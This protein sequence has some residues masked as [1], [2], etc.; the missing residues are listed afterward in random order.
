MSDKETVLHL[1]NLIIGKLGK[2]YTSSTTYDFALQNPI[3]VR[4]RLSSVFLIARFVLPTR[5]AKQ[6]TQRQQVAQ[7]P[8]KKRRATRTFFYFLVQRGREPNPRASYHSSTNLCCRLTLPDTARRISLRLGLRF[9][10]SLVASS[11]ATTP[12][13]PLLANFHHLD[14]SAALA[15]PSPIFPFSAQ[16]GA[17]IVLSSSVRPDLRLVSPYPCLV[18]R[19][20]RKGRIVFWDLFNPQHTLQAFDRRPARHVFSSS[21]SLSVITSSFLQPTSFLASFMVSR[22]L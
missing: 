4:P 14:S 19:F 7:T 1:F 2:F 9:D 5:P 3:S 22:W 21:E 12:A 20:R 18:L 15:P 10:H 16:I 8:E 17:A 6:N 11:Q 13:S